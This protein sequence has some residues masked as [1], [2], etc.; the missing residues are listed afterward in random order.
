MKKL[1]VFLFITSL[2][3]SCSSSDDYEEPIVTSIELESVKDDIFV[4]AEYQLKVAHTPIELQAP[5]YTWESSNTN[6]LIIDNNGKFKALSVGDVKISVYADELNLSS[7]I[8]VSV[9]AVE[10]T[11][12]KISE[13]SKELIVGE[14]FSLSYKIEPE[15]TTNKSVTWKSSNENV[16]IVSDNGQVTAIS[17]GDVTISVSIGSFKDECVIKVHPVRVTGVSLSK[18]SVAVEV[19]ESFKLESSITPISAK[20]KNVTW[21]SSNEEVAT[22]DNLG[23]VYAKGVG[24]AIITVV[25]E[26]G[27]FSASANV[28]VFDYLSKIS[29]SLSRSYTVTSAGAYTQVSGVL[30]NDSKKT[31]VAKKVSTYENGSFLSDLEINRTVL[32]GTEISYGVKRDGNFQFVYEC[33][34][35]GETFTVSSN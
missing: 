30:K 3:I 14:L 7:T 35:D 12:I 19:L 23:K 33:E 5:K 15:N 22:V 1:L 24:S 29:V 26:D 13:A 4:G 16:A 9:L 21:K 20:N 17:D 10:A 6:V 31:I 27:E 11:S 25:T 18:T 32:S 8:D 2:C 28:N 34:Y